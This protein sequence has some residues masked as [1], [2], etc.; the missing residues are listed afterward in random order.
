MMRRRSLV[1]MSGHILRSLMRTLEVAS[2]LNARDAGFR[3]TQ[4]IVWG[5]HT[6]YLLAISWVVFFSWQLMM[7]G[8]RNS[9]V[10]VDD[11]RSFAAPSSSQAA[12]ALHW[13]QATLPV[14]ATLLDVRPTGSIG[15]RCNRSI[16]AKWLDASR[17]RLTAAPLIDR[18]V[19]VA[20]C[21]IYELAG[22]T[23]V[24]LCVRLQP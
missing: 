12:D 24:N 4:Q 18:R 5:V 9:D 6:R 21:D 14:E 23:L 7:S 3:L 15:I 11:V 10:M 22:K 17:L 1:E 20:C 13:R 8:E 2:K 19:F 16:A